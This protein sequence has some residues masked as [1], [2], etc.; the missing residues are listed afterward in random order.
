MSA[1]LSFSETMSGPF[2]LGESDPDRGATAETRLTMH[3]TVEIDDIERFVAD[4]AHAGRLSGRVS[5]A[6]LSED[7]RAETGVFNLFS[8]S[9]EPTLKHMVYELGFEH[10]GQA[11]YLAGKKHVRDEA[12]FD[13]WKDT[14]TLFTLLHRGTDTTGQVVGAGILTLGVA[15]LARLVSTMRVNGSPQAVP[16]ALAR[17]GHF[18]MGEL[19]D[20][21]AHLS[22]R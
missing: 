8:P 11:Y 2:A 19:W 20:T 6:P 21:Y 14:T 17:F 9:G 16:E 3:A 10:A 1:G 15:D 4:P 5:F 7:I 22:G 13:V 18:F 12:G